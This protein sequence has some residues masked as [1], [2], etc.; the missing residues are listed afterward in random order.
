MLSA[1]IPSLQFLL[2]PDRS[3]KAVP[4]VAFPTHLVHLYLLDDQQPIA[5][6]DIVEHR[7]LGARHMR[8]S[9]Q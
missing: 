6:A 5:H 8:K 4:F 9:S 3:R 2:N 1:I 7:F